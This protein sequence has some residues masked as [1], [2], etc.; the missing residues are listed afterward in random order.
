MP[1]VGFNNPKIK[2]INVV[3]PDPDSPII[4]IIWPFFNFKFKFLKIYFLD[5]GYLKFMFLNSISP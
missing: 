1:D 5:E 4:P 2:S 3:L